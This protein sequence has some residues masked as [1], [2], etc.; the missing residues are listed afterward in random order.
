ME[1]IK[2]LTEELSAA[3]TAT[4]KVKSKAKP[5]LKPEHLAQLQSAVDRAIRNFDRKPVE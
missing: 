5:I 3:I 1:E 4:G 2:K